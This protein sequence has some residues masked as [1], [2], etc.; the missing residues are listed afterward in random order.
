V[1]PHVRIARPVADLALSVGMYVRGLDLREIG[2]FEDH[3]GFDGVMLEV[4][5]KGFH[6]E[7]THCRTHPI[8]PTPTAEDLLVFYVP[9]ADDWS[10]RCRAMQQ[11]GFAEVEAFNPYWAVR[12]RTFED[13]DG[14]RI[15][16]QRAAWGA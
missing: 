8:T 15:V 2:R 16:I 13:P 3:E 4:P 10:A 14:Y 7:F 12:G 9:S 6:F 5:G 11:A 1:S